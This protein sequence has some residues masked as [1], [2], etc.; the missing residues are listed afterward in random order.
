[1]Q[2]LLKIIREFD[3]WRL[4]DHESTFPKENF[5]DIHPIF[6]HEFEPNN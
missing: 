6:K 4:R 3:Y 2:V 5:I 1:M